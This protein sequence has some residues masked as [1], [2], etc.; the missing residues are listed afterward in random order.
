LS[1]PDRKAFET[2]PVFTDEERASFFDVPQWASKLIETF[3]TPRN[4]VGFLLQLGYFRSTN[5]FFIAKTFHPDDIAFVAKLL[6]IKQK[7][8]VSIAIR[9]QHM[10][11]TS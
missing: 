2:P 6:K 10:D 1:Q 8:L 7:R 9:E 5:S 3:R 11:G 4:K